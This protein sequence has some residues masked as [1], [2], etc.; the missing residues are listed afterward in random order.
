MEKENFKSGFVVFL[1]RPNVGKSTILN[2]LVANKV[3]IVSPIPQTTRHQIKGILNLENAQVVFLDTPGVHSFKDELA[4]HLN[5]VAKKS[6]DGCDVLLYVVD[7]SRRLGKEERVIAKIVQAQNIKV[8]VVFNKMDL[9]NKYLN[10]YVKFCEQMFQGKESKVY[11]IPLS[12]KTGRNIDELRDLI[13]ESLPYAEPY[14]DK[15]TLTDF[16]LKF[17]IADVVREKLC[18]NLEREVPH[19]VAVEVESIEERKTRKDEDI[20]DVRINIY[21]TRQ[22]QKKIVIGSKGIVLKEVGR[23]ARPEIEAICGKK[24]FLDIWVKV[25]KDWQQK[26]RVLKEL[27]YWWV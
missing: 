10:D 7:V 2:A 3:S 22:S 13:V 8:I 4:A 20:V 23:S 27:G 21:V 19:S 25:L 26:P 12:A 18:L 24:V 1:G 16:P 6:L 5:T 17:R 15:D 9:G 11:Y 14:Y